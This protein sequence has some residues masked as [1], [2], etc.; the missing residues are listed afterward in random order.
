MKICFL[1]TSQIFTL[2]ENNGYEFLHKLLGNYYVCKEKFLDLLSLQKI[3][4]KLSNFDEVSCLVFSR[5]S[6]C[7]K[8]N[9]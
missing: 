8:R 4:I 2:K 7:S 9:C 6:C 3:C 1:D 5:E